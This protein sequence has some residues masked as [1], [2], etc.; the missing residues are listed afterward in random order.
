MPDAKEKP[1]RYDPAAFETR[2][3]QEWERSGVYEAK[4][5]AGKEKFY[6]L[7]EFPYP[8]GDGLHVGHV[9][10]YTAM[11]TIARKRRM[12]GYSV[13]FPMGWD[14]FGLPTE[15]FAIKTGIHPAIVTKKNTDTFRAQLKRV[16]FSFD[17]TREVNTTD[18]AFYKWTQWMFIRM[19]EAGLAYK[20][21]AY[22]NWCPVDRVGLANEEV[23]GGA[24]ERCGALVVQVEKEQWMVRITAYAEQLLEGLK[25]TDFLPEIKAQQE[26]WIGRSAGAEIGFPIEGGRIDVFTT[27]PDTL[28]GVTY[29]VL[30]PEHPLVKERMDSFANRDAVAAYVAQ[31]GMKTE[32][33]RAIEAG[34]TG[35]RLEGLV[36]KHPVTGSE[37]PVWIADYVLSGYGTGA[38]MAVPAHDERDAA[39]A[40]EHGL[41]VIEVVNEEGTLVNSGAFDGRSAADAKEEIAKAAG[42]TMRVQYKLRDWVF[43][44]QRYWGEPVPM[45]R[46]AAGCGTDGWVP[47]PEDQLPVV[48]PEV[49]E[50]RPGENGESPLASIADWVDTTCPSCGGAAKRET[51]VM[52]QW[53]GSSWYF[54][55]YV[56]P[57][58]DEAFASTDKLRYWMPVDWYNGGMEHVT[59]HLLYSRFWNRFLYD[60]GLVPFAEPYVKRT[61]HGMI[62]GEGGKKMSKSKGNVVN[63]DAV[64]ESHGADALRVYEMFMGPFNQAI[65]WDTKS[66]EGS[67]RF[68][69]RA[70][71]LAG[72][73]GGEDAAILRAAKR[74]A[75]KVG[76]DIEAMSFNTAI[77]ALMV[78]VNDATKADA[79]PQEAWELF[80]RA[81][82]PFAPHLAEELWHRAGHEDS[83]HLA[84]WPEVDEADLAEETV[85]I[86]VQVGGKSRDDI[87]VPAGASQEEV[88]A[89]A[90]GSERVTRFLEGAE[91]RKVVYVPGRIINFVV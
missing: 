7:V 51:D 69:A 21:K 47:V 70:H 13:I 87:E 9:R 6:G 3:Q 75:K 30:A 38:I 71:A 88:V 61:A 62:L 74:T 28:F 80:L 11:D 1:E 23:V 60:Q 42:G 83:V 29:L 85:R 54:L 59:L 76:D 20:G 67:Y 37:L 32:R 17:W 5:V 66:I 44:R 2:W 79:V 78:W 18:P 46:C 16:G 25:D 56:D 27:R 49:T 64:V 84:A 68:L 45:I 81:L 86:A 26:N 82:A 57:N 39:F 89:M 41:P 48:L 10:S 12:Q 55:R 65:A 36:A 14:A 33:E 73:V 52:P 72:K 24:C 43:S 22:I 40:A 34:K 31:A 4:E 15:N 91:V 8:S 90:R 50:F 63:P 77:S 35:V 58:N 19:F 53:A